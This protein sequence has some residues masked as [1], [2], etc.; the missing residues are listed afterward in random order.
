M[1]DALR[2]LL[3]QA[4]TIAVVGLSPNPARPSHAVARYLQQ[5]GYRIIPV[6]PNAREVLGER[7][8]PT[9]TRAAQDHEIDIVDVFRRSA[10][11]GDLVHEALPLAPR[12]I[13]LQ[14]GV[15]DD[16]AA[17][18]ARAAGIPF[19]MDRCL[20]VEH[21]HLISHAPEAE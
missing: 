20:A 4:R 19:V 10:H 2:P 11:V 3:Q 1:P 13:W 14:Q 21:E 15:R 6:N 9:L 7:S 17:A 8:Y 12:L 16:A 5:A 18:L